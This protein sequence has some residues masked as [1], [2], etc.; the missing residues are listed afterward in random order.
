MRYGCNRN[1]E[2]FFI[3]NLPFFVQFEANGETWGKWWRANTGL[4]TALPCEFRAR[5]TAMWYS[6]GRDFWKRVIVGIWKGQ[7]D[8]RC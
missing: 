1:V 5:T 6:L 7:R 4:M 3:I 2:Y 8:R